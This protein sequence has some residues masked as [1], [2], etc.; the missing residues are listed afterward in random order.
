M[1]A[2]KELIEHH[3]EDFPDFAYYMPIIDKVF[4]YQESR[5]DTC[6]EC[7][8][9][10]FQGICKTIVLNLD[11][12]S[13]LEELERPS[14]GKSDKLVKRAL[15]CLNSEDDTVEMGFSQSCAGLA[16]AISLLRNKR[17]DITHGKAV[18]KVL[19]SNMELSRSVVEMTDSLLRYM[20]ASYFARQ[21]EAR[22]HA[23]EMEAKSSEPDEEL[24]DYNHN[25]DF[26]D[27]LDEINPPE[28]KVIYSHALFHLYLEEY[29][30]EL[31]EFRASQE[32]ESG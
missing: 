29:Q 23:R 22:E 18:P 19:Y 11:A 24:A 20:L 14:E 4:A 2:V 26:N 13:T 30:I 5:P 15:R 12:T 16:S 8:N 28:G 17:G 7:C 10:L 32:D 6:I 21:I 27:Y 1:K 3:S 31:E 9:S 25:P